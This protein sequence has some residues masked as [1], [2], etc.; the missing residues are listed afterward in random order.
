M[1]TRNHSNGA[2][3]KGDKS[4]ELKKRIYEKSF[5]WD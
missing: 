4:R 3:L 5:I 2:N 1:E